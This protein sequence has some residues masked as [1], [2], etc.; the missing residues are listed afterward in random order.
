MDSRCR[1]R[2]IVAMRRG[3]LTGLRNMRRW[4][5][6]AV[7]LALVLPALVAL[8]PQPA[9]SASAALERDL[10]VSVCGRS[11]PLPDHS[12]QHQVT[13]DHCVL[14]GNH[15][16]GCSPSLAGAGPAF[17]PVPRDG[18]RPTAATSGAIAPPLQAL[19]ES[20]PPRGPPT[21]A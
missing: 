14:C 7:A 20:S 2:Q 4:F 13:H 12:G 16:P 21:L 17:A 15:C 6:H 19:L 5:V 11:M 18:A 9:L 3:P 1:G 10:L 8:L